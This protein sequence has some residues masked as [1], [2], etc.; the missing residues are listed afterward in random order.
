MK[1]LFLFLLSLAIGFGIFWLVTEKIGWQAILQPLSLFRHWQGIVIFLLTLFIAGLNIRRWQFILKTQG[2]NF[3]LQDLGDIWLAG[4][5]ISYL[6]PIAIFGGETFMGIGLKRRFALPWQKNIASIFILR[7]LNLT[8]TFLFLCLGVIT[9]L[10]SVGLPPENIFLISGPT[11]LSLGGILAIFYYQSFRRKSIFK[12]FLENWGRKF[13]RKNF[14]N[15][16]GIIQAEQEIFSFFN[17]RN[18]VMWQGLTLAFFSFCLNLIR[19]WFIIFFLEGYFI[20]L[21]QLFA[22]FAF[23][24]LAYILPFPAALGSLEASQALVFSSL[25]LGPDLGTAF[26]LILRGAELSLAFLGIFFFLKLWFRFR[27]L[28]WLLE[29]FAIT[30]KK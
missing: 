28:V 7:I 20:N 16:Q 2:Y 29:K 22:I 9:F 26:S 14:L 15:S 8:C 21:L 12:R 10:I 4:N 27:L 6:T 25:G 17:P 19:F 18:K 5:T 13:T 11:I 3:S 1:K 24:T 23:V 30:S